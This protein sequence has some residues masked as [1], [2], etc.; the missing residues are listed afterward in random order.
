[1]SGMV[2]DRWTLEAFEPMTAIPT[3]VSLTTYS[4]GVEEF[5]AMPLQRLVDEVEMGMLPVKVGRVVRLDEIAEAHRCMEADEAGGKI[6]VL[7]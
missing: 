5:M 4:R 3:A 2:G 1:M 6:V 7:P